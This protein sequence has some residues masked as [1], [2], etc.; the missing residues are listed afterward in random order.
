V[1]LPVFNHLSERQLSLSFT[2]D[3]SLGIMLL[4]L[5][6]FVGLLAGI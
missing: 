2:R 4:L 6:L 5:I 3:Y 1:V